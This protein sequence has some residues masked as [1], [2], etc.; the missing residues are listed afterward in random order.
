MLINV[1]V[2]VQGWG[3]IWIAS[4]MTVSALG[5][6]WLAAW[7]AQKSFGLDS[8]E[9]KLMFGLSGGKA[10]ATIAA[11]MIGYKYGMINEDLMN[12]AVMMILFCCLVASVATESAA[13][14]IRMSMTEADLSHDDLGRKEFAR[15]VVSVANP[16]TAEELMRMA[17][18]MRDRKNPN[19]ATALFVRTDGDRRRQ[20]MGR[21]ALTAATAVGEA[22]DVRVDSVERVDLNVVNGI[23]NVAE[24]KNATEIM[25]GFHRKANLVDTFF[26]ALTEQLLASSMKMVMMSR[27]FI[28]VDTVTRIFVLVPA[29]AEYET[30]FHLWVSRMSML[31]SNIEASIAFV[32]HKATNDFIS[33]VIEDDRIEVDHRFMAIESDDDIILLA[34]EIDDN[35]LLVVVGARKGS[36][37]FSSQMESLPGFLSRHFARHN[38]LVLYPRQF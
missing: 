22:M 12:G 28:P 30:G 32:G 38:L 17:M 21:M 35:D 20:A 15:Q 36:I 6:K 24:E 5:S 11:V 26:G 1:R 9:R 33:S 34:G 19:D 14:N 27:C 7:L 37:S 4:V 2:V 18:F 23:C 31:A 3:V 13:K 29:K 10:A 25:I 16:V 8:M